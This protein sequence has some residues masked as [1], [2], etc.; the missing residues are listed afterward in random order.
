MLL[1]PRVTYQV[2]LQTDKL[3]PCLQIPVGVA[4]ENLDELHQICTELVA[5]LQNAQHHYV[6]VPKVIPDVAGQTF[7]PAGEMSSLK[8]HQ[9]VI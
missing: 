4:P 5:P 2:A 6:V 8:T 9:G 7:Y 1:F 3:H